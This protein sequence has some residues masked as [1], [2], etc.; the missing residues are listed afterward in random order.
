MEIKFLKDNM[1]RLEVDRPGIIK[2]GVE[3]SDDFVMIR[4]KRD[5]F[6]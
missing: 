4:G 1:M 5:Q 2:I 3:L 6:Y